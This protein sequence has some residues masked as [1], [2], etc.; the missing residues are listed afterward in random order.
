[1]YGYG[2]GGDYGCGYGGYGGFGGE[3]LWIVIIIFII[4]F[5]CGW[6]NNNRCGC[7]QNQR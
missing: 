5:I 1:M 6:G 2:Y 3:W 7:C 4:F